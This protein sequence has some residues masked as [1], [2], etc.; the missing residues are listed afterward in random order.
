MYIYIH[1]LIYIIYTHL[2]YAYMCTW[3]VYTWNVYVRMYMYGEY[4]KCIYIC[5]HIYMCIFVYIYIYIY[6]CIYTWIHIHMCN[7]H[8]NSCVIIYTFQHHI[9]SSLCLK[10]E[11]MCV[12]VIT[13]TL[14]K[15]KHVHRYIHTGIHGYVYTYIC[16]YIWVCSYLY[17]YLHICTSINCRCVYK[18][19]YVYNIN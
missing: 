10:F 4:M 3:N 16:I 19:E 18:H 2:L 17:T 1:V 7:L 6:I 9:T 8:L 14:M 12:S 11:Y 5:I 13:C 15:H